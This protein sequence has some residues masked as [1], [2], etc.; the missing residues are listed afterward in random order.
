MRG[1]RDLVK[2]DVGDVAEV[3]ATG[4]CVDVEGRVVSDHLG[5]DV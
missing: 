3:D 2:A 1:L 4:L 5:E